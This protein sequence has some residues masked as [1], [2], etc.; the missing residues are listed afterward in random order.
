MIKES[1]SKKL[2]KPVLWSFVFAVLG[3][4]FS[5]GIGF[6]ALT[7]TGAGHG[8]GLYAAL[9]R[10]PEPFGQ[11]IWPLIGLLVPWSCRK[12]RVA[13]LIGL[14]AAINYIAAATAYLQEGSQY[15]LRTFHS[16]PGVTVFVVA[17]YLLVQ[18]LVALVVLKALRT[19]NSRPA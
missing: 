7:L 19:G 5:E 12:R 10:G 8:S 2:R 3:T 4:I 1:V 17:S 18:F 15:A 11:F 14:L 6:V 13:V 16:D 9:I